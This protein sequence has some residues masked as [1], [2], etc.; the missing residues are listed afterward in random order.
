MNEIAE[1]AP[2]AALPRVEPAARLA[3]VRHGAEF[4]VDRASSVPARVEFV[5]GRL[6]GFFVFEAGVDVADEVC[7]GRGGGGVS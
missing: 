4:A 2:H 5:A 7:G 3:E 6:G 1:P